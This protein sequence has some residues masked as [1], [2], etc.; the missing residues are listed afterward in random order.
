MNVYSAR[1]IALAAG[2]AENDV[3]MAL[4]AAGHSGGFAQ[5]AAAVEIGRAL[6]ARARTAERARIQSSLF[7][8]F[9]RAAASQTPKGLPFAVSGTL[10][11]GMIAAAVFMTALATSPT[12]ATAFIER[13]NE[14]LRF[15]FVASPGPGG[16]GGG[17]GLKQPTPPPKALREGPRKISSP[18][19]QREPP[20]PIEAAVTPPEP[21]PV[22]LKAEPLPAL[23]APIVAAPA[24]RETRIGALEQTIAQN[25]SRGPGADGGV[26]S[27]AGTGIGEGDGPGVGPGSGG[28]IGGGPYRPGSG[29]EPPRLLREVRADYTEEARRANVEGDVLLE[30]VV[31]RDGTVG[32]PRIVKSLGRG[33]DQRAVQAVRQWRFV[34]ARRLGTPVDVIVEVSVEFRLR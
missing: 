30:I 8:V 31:R 15:V 6:V 29:I 9:S 23:I 13:D 32:D 1:E 19:P 16:G 22:P 14:P 7:S 21:E 12:T 10:H 11:G 3:L 25:D 26:G 2:V 18:L 28:G 17:G 34:P 4:A 27:G 5:H 24:D 33:L 20:K